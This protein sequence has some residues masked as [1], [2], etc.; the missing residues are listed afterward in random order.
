[1][2]LPSVLLIPGAWH[3]P[4]HFGPLIDELTDVDV[5][6]VT[7]TSSGDDPTTLRDMH[8]DAEM[9]AE[10]VAAIDRP[11]VVV[12]HSYGGLPATQGL[13]NSRNVRHLVFLASFQMLD[14]DSLLSK[15]PGGALLPWAQLH[16]REGVNDF[17]EAMT[18]ETVFFNDL[19][20]A[21][22]ATAVNQ[23]GYQSYASMRQPL[24]ET[25]WIN[26]PNT[27]VVCERDN[28]IPVAAQ[29]MMAQRADRVHRLKT[30][31]SPFISQPAAV[32]G[33]IRSALASA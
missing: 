15:N 20:A 10:A 17:V 5:H 24:T 21:T 8:S 23:L 2:T 28:A 1:M 3:K 11:V 22:A 7:L 12:A 30:S 32:A 26:I 14:G 19:D 9:I 16:Q 31:H 29:E 4:I 25:A 18:P 6:T 33:L 13:T 27:Y